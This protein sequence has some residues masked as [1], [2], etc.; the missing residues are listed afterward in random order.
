MAKSVDS[1]TWTVGGGDGGG[2]GAYI[3]F[4]DPNS[5]LFTHRN[6]KPKGVK[7]VKVTRSNIDSLAKLLGKVADQVIVETDSTVYEGDKSEP[8]AKSLYAY[9]DGDQFVV[10]ESDWVIEEYDYEANRPTYRL[11]TLK[12]RKKH[13]LR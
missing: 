9:F 12:D 3:T 2:N 8:G 6:P 4:N 11:A 1:I 13:D 7:A 10:N 5:S